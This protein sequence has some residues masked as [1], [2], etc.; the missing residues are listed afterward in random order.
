LL[1]DHAARKET[2]TTYG[3]QLCNVIVA[4]V[5]PHLGGAAAASASASESASASSAAAMTPGMF[6][7][8]AALATCGLTK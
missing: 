8:A 3:G 7:D 6:S 4:H 1:A 2:R 5:R